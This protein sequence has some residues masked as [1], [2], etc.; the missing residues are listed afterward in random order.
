MP[1][2][3][4]DIVET[5]KFAEWVVDLL[6]YTWLVKVLLEHGTNCLYDLSAGPK[7]VKVLPKVASEAAKVEGE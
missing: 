5:K 6:W 1:A 4:K 3:A 7:A 2:K